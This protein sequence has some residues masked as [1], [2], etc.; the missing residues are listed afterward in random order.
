MDQMKFGVKRLSG[1]NYETW[2]YKMELFLMN[3]G[4]LEVATLETAEG[5]RNQEWIERD[6][7][8]R[9]IS[10]LS[11]EDSQVVHVRGCFGKN[12]KII[13]KGFI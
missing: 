8:A 1:D 2:R 11:I 12:W 6:K 10:G 13:T 4:L 5:D 7:K 3:E 9:A